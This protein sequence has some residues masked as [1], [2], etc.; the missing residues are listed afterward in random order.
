[1]WSE[2]VEKAVSD[3]AIEFLDAFS[4]VSEVTTT[5][6]LA[7]PLTLTTITFVGELSARS[8]DLEAVEMGMMLCDG[9]QQESIGFALTGGAKDGGARKPKRQK[10]DFHNQLPLVTPGGKGVKLFSNGKVHVTGCSSPVQ[11]LDIVAQLCTLLPSLVDLGDLRLEVFHIEM[12]NA[13]FSVCSTNGHHVS[14][15]PNRLTEELKKMDIVAD[16]ETERHPGVK[17]AIRDEDGKKVGTVMIFRTGSVQ[18]CGVK[19]PR[20]LARAFVHTCTNIDAIVRDLGEAVCVECDPRQL[21]TTTSKHPFHIVEG[22]PTSLFNACI[23][24]C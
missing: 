16:F 11:F 15:R 6:I 8:I 20:H 3:T 22:Y 4:A 7:M 23:G 17:V 19:H 14:L 21:R 18:I 12:I 1:M 24:A 13:G 2:A 5:H 9:L 10:K